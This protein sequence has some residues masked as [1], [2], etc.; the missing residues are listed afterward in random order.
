MSVIK[1]SPNVPSRRDLFRLAAAAGVGGLGLPRGAAAAGVTLTF[2]HESS[3]IK[4]YDTYMQKTLVPAYEKESGNK[5]R[6]ELLSVGSL[7][8]RVTTAAETGQGPDIT[9]NFFNWPYL[10]NEKYIDVSDIA[11]E[12]GRLNGGWTDSVKEAVVVDGKWKA[13]PFGNVGQ[14]MVWR[15]DMFKAAGINAFPD[16]WEELYAAGVKLKVKGTPLGFELGHGF[17]DNHGWLYPLL[18]SYGA[19]EVL[20]DGKT[21]VLDSSETAAAVDYC[22]R[23]FKDTMNEEVLGWTDPNNNKSFLSEQISCTNNAASI[24]WFAKNDFPDM[25]K[26]IAHAQNP[27]GPKGRFHILAPWSHSIFTHSKNQAAAKDFLRWLMN[28]KQLRG[29]L[30]SADTY[31]APFLKAFD[32]DPMWNID[33]RYMPYRDSLATAHL[34]GWPAPVSRET[35]QSVA[36]YVVVDMFAKAC[37][38]AS[39]REVIANAVA[40]LKQIYGQS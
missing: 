18:W 36:K 29:W 25:A 17:G 28:P 14:L 31:Y 38:G 5:L 19:A 27:A 13:V 16:T 35:S 21:I 12:A 30:A 3:F 20:P 33:P 8:T 1:T 2:M 26:M 9:L 24:L 39:T 4:A 22:R 11:E 10:Y 6:Y 40:Q 15:T 37:A 23:L 32:T 7:Q 34:P